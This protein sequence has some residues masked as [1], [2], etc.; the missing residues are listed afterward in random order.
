MSN[1]IVTICRQFCSGGKEI[2]RKLAEKLDYKFYDN[3]LIV[4][5]A[6]EA[7]Y[8][9]SA[10]ERVD[11]VA[12][13]SLL[14]SLVLGTY[15]A[16][17]AAAMPDNDKLFGIQSEIIRKAAKDNNCVIIGRCSDYVLREE[18]KLV[19]VFIRA[20]MDYRIN[21]FNTLFEKP[22]NKTVEAVIKKTD[23]RRAA[24]HKFYSGEAWE[25]LENYDLVINTAKIS[26][27]CAVA[28]IE[29]YVEQL[30]KVK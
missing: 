2:G 23:K 8:S 22:E 7:G 30:N 1:T 24:Y 29:N 28:L 6:K 19:K 21:R 4:M 20:D 9:E 18:K 16:N 15:G 26:E 27:D 5:A 13:N 25:E 12:T 14:Y 3:E 10:F 11:E 17:G